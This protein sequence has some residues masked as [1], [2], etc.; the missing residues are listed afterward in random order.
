MPLPRQLF[1]I[2]PHHCRSHKYSCILKILLNDQKFTVLDLFV[3]HTSESIAVSVC[4]LVTT[5][6]VTWSCCALSLSSSVY[7]LL[8]LNT[9]MLST[10]IVCS[11]EATILSTSFMVG[12]LTS[13]L[14]CALSFCTGP[15]FAPLDSSCL[16]DSRTVHAGIVAP[17]SSLLP[18]NKFPSMV[19]Y[20]MFWM[21]SS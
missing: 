3:E 19:Y 12:V 15:G 14:N 16:L 4:C 8:S 13:S 7:L 20:C 6:S 5:V 21:V 9:W 10:N 18:V 17:E 1:Q 2:T 11:F